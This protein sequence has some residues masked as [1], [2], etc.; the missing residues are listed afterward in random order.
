MLSPIKIG[1][2]DFR[3]LRE[4]GAFYVDK[5][6]MIAE[7]LEDPNL[8]LLLPR[9]RRFG[10][11]LNLTMLQAFFDDRQ[12]SDQLFAHLAVA[13]NPK[14]MAHLNTFPTLFLT[15]KDMDYHDWPSCL[16]AL[17]LRIAKLVGEHQARITPVATPAER[18]WLDTL[19][20]GQAD[21]PICE[22]A[23]LLLTELLCRTSGRK[24]VVLID[25]YDNPI[26]IASSH[27]YQDKILSF[28]RNFLGA[29]LKDNPH[30]ERAVITGI[31][32]VGKESIYSGLNHLGV[33]ALLDQP[34]ATAFGFGEEEVA[35]ILAHSG[36]SERLP[37]VRDWYN[38]YRIGTHTIYNPWSILK[39]ASLPQAPLQAHWINTSG[40]DLIRNLV[41]E[42][43]AT[44]LADLEVLLAG[45]AIR[46]TL[47]A[48][49]ALREL[50]GDDLWNLLVFSGYL[51]TTHFDPVTNQADLVL[52]N[53]EIR[54]FFQ[55]VVL[56]WFGSASHASKLV[57]HLLSGRF[58]DFQTSLAEAVVTILSYYDTA[59]PQPEK[60]Y[61]V[62]ILGLLV[63]ISDRYRIV[64]N[65]EA[66]HGRLDLAL[67]PRRAEDPGFI[68]EFKNAA[69]SEEQILR[70]TAEQALEQAKD[71]DYA[72]AFRH[73]GI[74]QVTLF[75]LAC[76]GKRI[77]LVWCADSR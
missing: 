77:A 9:P 23:L 12:R 72:A 44:F 25:E 50:S 69:S 29:G 40:N 7:L 65:R 46:K 58:E 32:R 5:T 13:D 42:A 4:T 57:D 68:F 38:G 63:Q 76:H 43:P 22:Q 75:G 45:G 49:V 15:L 1:Q 27:G 66:G 6:A 30:L 16:A 36:Q 8:V 47:F 70:H 21:Q 35:E 41:L 14:A 60:I 20:L 37:E 48:N 74:A 10:K 64:S 54:T 56:Q 18:N 51:T 62:F 31:L 59:D 26:H 55:Q 34:F 67:F 3:S 52:P 17:K 2:S 24:I 53:R 33:Y 11:T 61:H 19:A 73:E 71:R 39:M 28:L